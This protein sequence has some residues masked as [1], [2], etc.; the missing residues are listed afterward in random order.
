MI[1]C[2]LLYQY[3][4]YWFNFIHS[5]FLSSL[6]HPSSLP[7]LVFISGSFRDSLVVE[8]GCSKSFLIVT[9]NQPA[10]EAT[11]RRLF[12][13]SMI[14]FENLL[15][16]YL[17]PS[18]LFQLPVSWS[19]FHWNGHILYLP[20]LRLHSKNQPILFVF[21]TIAQ[22]YLE[23]NRIALFPSCLLKTTC[24][25]TSSGSLLWLSLHYWD[26]FK[27]W[28]ILL[29]CFIFLSAENIFRVIDITIEFLSCA[30][31]PESSLISYHF[32]CDLNFLFKMWTECLWFNLWTCE[33]TC[34]QIITTTTI[35]ICHLR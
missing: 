9:G 17:L 8:W 30:C 10:R 20:S 31:L 22:T 21:I 13:F 12:V 26:T 34:F 19:E 32:H 29:S 28:N 25:F 4:L 15:F 33:L 5:K 35:R 3:I 7:V 6:Y 24:S 23:L 14:A 18:V 11:S 2:G 1:E 27:K 16:L